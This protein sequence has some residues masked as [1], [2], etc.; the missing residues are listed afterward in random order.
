[1]IQPNV[2][3][4]VPEAFSRQHAN[5]RLKLDICSTGP[6]SILQPELLCE[7]ENNHSTKTKLTYYLQR[8]FSKCHKAVVFMLR[9]VDELL[10]KM[11]R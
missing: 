4:N 9:P 10:Q 2:R 1:M 5:Y 8:S 3:T 11:A 6:C 7:D